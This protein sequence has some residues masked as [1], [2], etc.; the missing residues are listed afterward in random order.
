MKTATLRK[1]KNADSINSKEEYVLSL[2]VEGSN[3][4]FYFEND[5]T[6][7]SDKQYI[8]WIDFISILKG[9][10]IS[11]KEELDVKGKDFPIT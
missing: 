4:E 2:L 6:Q 9:L 8:K 7:E 1:I 10:D 3:K 5:T 11:I